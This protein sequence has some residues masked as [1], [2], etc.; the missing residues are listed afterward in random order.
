MW[1]HKRKEN[2]RGTTADSYI[3]FPA[4]W[5]PTT[6]PPRIDVAHALWP[7]ASQL[8]LAVGRRPPR[9]LARA[10]ASARAHAHE[11][12]CLHS[13]SPT[14]SRSHNRRRCCEA[15][16]P[17]WSLSYRLP[18]RAYSNNTFACMYMK[19]ERTVLAICVVADRRPCLAEFTARPSLSPAPL[20][21]CT[22]WPLHHHHTHR[23]P[24][25]ALCLPV[26]AK[27]V[28]TGS[29][30]SARTSPHNA[31]ACSSPF[32]TPRRASRPLRYGC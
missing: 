1:N 16:P 30:A 21:R 29:S 17:P 6:S 8:Y 7:A 27:T 4:L 9:F 22:G 20:G 5:Q 32:A 18:F 11:L 13:L 19:R 31:S 12:S 26:S 23:A 15:L 2:G 25:A 3:F 28:T 24:R 10:A 14:S